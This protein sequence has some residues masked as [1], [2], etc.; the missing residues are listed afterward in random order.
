MRR[1]GSA[2]V[3]LTL[4]MGRLWGP[5]VGGA[6]LLGRM[7]RLVGT[8]IARRAARLVPVAGALAITL[9]GLVLTLQAIPAAA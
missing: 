2:L 4:A 7:P 6:S 5:V 1:L 8:P 9:A 3:V